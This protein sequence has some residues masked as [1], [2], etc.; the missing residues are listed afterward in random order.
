M[1]KP[2]DNHVLIKAEDVPEFKL[3]NGIIITNPK[4]KTKKGEIVALGDKV[5]TVEV[6]DIVEFTS[7]HCPEVDG[8]FLVNTEESD[9]RILFVYN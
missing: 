8:F 2:A 4:T 7:L 6:G 1:I 9:C 3:T 5:G